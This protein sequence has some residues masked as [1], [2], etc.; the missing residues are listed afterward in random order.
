[1]RLSVRDDGAGMDP[2]KPNPERYGLVGIRERADAIGA[3]VRFE[4]RLGVGTAVMIEM[5]ASS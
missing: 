1:V 2:T 4:S 5:E 3:R